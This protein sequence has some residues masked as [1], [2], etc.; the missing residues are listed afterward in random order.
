MFLV[1]SPPRNYSEDEHMVIRNFV[2][3]YY[4]FA[5]TSTAVYGNITV[6]KSEPGLLKAL[7]INS[8][9]DYRMVQLDDKFGQIHFWCEIEEK[10]V[11]SDGT[12]LRSMCGVTV[13]LIL[14]AI[15]N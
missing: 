2:D 5:A 3:M 14:V 15:I 7:E 8:G 11:S 9:S 4:N 10:L 6:E 13:M 12:K 1:G